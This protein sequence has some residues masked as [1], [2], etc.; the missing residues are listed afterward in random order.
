MKTLE[1]NRLI[2]RSWH[3]LDLDDLHEFISNKKVADLAGFKVRKNKDESLRLLQRFIIDSNDSLWAI[4]L[5]DANKVIGWIE[6]H[7][8]TEKTFSGSREI[9]AALSERFWGQG[10]IPEAIRLVLEYLIKEDIYNAIYSHFIYNVQSEKAI[11]KCGFE[12]YLEACNKKYYFK[13]IK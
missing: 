3:I 1:G 10:L 6:L 11:K 13:R 12:L 7:E 5:K 2:L 9:G 4:E 8:P